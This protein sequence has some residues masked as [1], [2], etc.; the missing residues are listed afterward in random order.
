ML[1]WMLMEPNIVAVIK[2]PTGDMTLDIY[3]FFEHSETMS[4]IH[5]HNHELSDKHGDIISYVMKKFIDFYATFLGGDPE[6]N[7]FDLR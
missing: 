5:F 2:L 7:L 3:D 1:F 6:A 4:F